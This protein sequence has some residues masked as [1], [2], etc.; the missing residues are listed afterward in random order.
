MIPRS[1]TELSITQLKELAGELGSLSPATVATLR[2]LA[3]SEY[4]TAL[5][6]AKADRAATTNEQV[7]RMYALRE[8]VSTADTALGGTDGTPSEPAGDTADRLAQLAPVS[9]NAPAG[10]P[11]PATG[12]DDSTAGAAPTVA[13]IAS[14]PLVSAEAATAVERT[15]ARS[16]IT[17][18]ASLNG[19]APGASITM[20]DLAA[21]LTPRIHGYIGMSGGASSD[22]FARVTAPPSEFT[23]YGDRRDIEVIG[24][25]VDE[26]RVEGGSLVAARL[27][28]FQGTGNL[29]SLTASAGWCAQ[30]EIDRDV[31]FTGSA[32]GLLDVPTVTAMRGGVWIVPELTFADVYGTSG[33]NY[34]SF[35]EAQIIA[36][37]TKN[38][39]TL[40][41]PTPA[42]YRLG[43]TGFGLIAGLLQLR[44]YPEYV[45]EYTRAALIGLEHLRSAANIAAMVA[46]STATNLTAVAP[47][48]NDG[49]VLSQLLA[50]AEMA[51][52]DQRYRFRL[53]RTATIEQVFPIWVLSQ[54][55]A[56]FMRRNGTGGDPALADAWIA[57]WFADQKIAPQFVYGWQDFYS[58]GGSTPGAATPITAFPTS[59]QFLSYPAGTWVNAVADVIQLST[60][61]D[62]TRLASNERIE[63]FTER[64]NRMIPRLTGSRVYTIGICPN[65]S[66]GVQRAVACA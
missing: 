49:S 16:A 42:E 62:S 17:A 47:W 4:N 50:A 7:D 22:P 28:A 21:A 45:R 3:S 48:S 53:E 40:D 23:V 43:V 33:G 34:F 41:C 51:A 15:L 57:R 52:V 25:A 27:A 35:T 9:V 58:A 56:D 39:V 36:G 46:G 31:R 11:A 2:E 63:F 1:V 10:A 55:R 61:Y 64:G 29:E 19:F 65:G 20:D 26:S 30:S 60:V 54:L 13:D 59:V 37:S 8:F 12:E 6:V 38:F 18:S 5:S 44:A 66:T 32:T 24:R 14:N